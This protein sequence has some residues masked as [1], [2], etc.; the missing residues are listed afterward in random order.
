M[1]MRTAADETPTDDAD[2]Q[3]FRGARWKRRIFGAVALLLVGLLLFAWAQRNSIADRFVQNAFAARGVTA[4]YKIDTIGFRTQRIRDLVIG[5]PAQPD[6]TAKLLEIDVALNF[7]GANLRDVRADGV[8]L[9]GRYANGKISFGELDKFTD[10]KST[11][12]LELPDIALSLKNARA[13]IETP[14]GVFNAAANGSGLLRNRFTANLSVRSPGVTAA[15]CSAS[16]L[17]FD[18]KLMLEWRQPHLVGPITATAAKCADAGIAI[19]A[20]RLDADIKLSERFNRWEGTLGYATANLVIPQAQLKDVAGKLTI[21]GDLKRTNFA[22]LLDKAALRSAP[23]SVGRLQMDSKGYAGLANG[24]LALSVSGN[25]ALANGALDRGTVGDLRGLVAQTQATPVGPIVARMAPVLQ[26]A[27]DR[28]AARLDFESFQDFQGR[29]GGNISALSLTSASGVRLRQIGSFGVSGSPKGWQLNAPAQLTLSGT[30]LPDIR[31]SIAQAGQSW[32]GNLVIAPYSAG[33]AR[34]AVSNLAF[35]GNPGGAWRFQGQAKMSGPLPGGYVSGL[36]LPIAGRY[37]AGAVSL[38]DSC[39]NVRFDSLKMSSLALRGSAFWL[40]PDRGRSMFSIANGKAAFATNIAGFRAN[41]NLG[42]TPISGRSATVRFSLDEGFAARNVSIK[43][44]AEDAQSAFDVA[45]LSGRFGQDG[46]SG[47]L[48]GGAGEIG[49]VPLLMDNASG[50]WRYADDILTLNGRLGVTDAE[51]VDRFEPMIVPD[52][53]LTLENNVITAIGHLVEPTT[54]TRVAGVDIRH[55]L[56]SAT[57]RALLAVD[58]LRFT[59]RFQPDLLTS[60]VL[61]VAANVDGT[62]SGD[63]RIEWDAQG[64]RSTGK[65]ATRGM[66]LAAAFGPVEGLNTEIVFTDLLGLETGAAQ[67]AE[68]A[69]INPGVPA[70]G[71]KINYRLLPDR[72]V[73]IE[74][75]RWPFAGGELILEPTILDFEVES[76]R[77][78]TFRVIGVDAEKLLAGYDFQNLRVTGVFDGTLPMIFNQDGGRIVGGSLVSREGGG[79]VSYLGELTYK[80]MGVFANYAFSALRSIRYSTLTIG[81]GGDL[82]G[83]IVTDISFTGLQQGSLAKRNFITRQLARI[84]IKF[85]VSVTAEFMKLIGSIRGLYD[86]NYAADRDLQYLLEE[87]RA[88]TDAKVPASVQPTKETANE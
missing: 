36:N 84:P 44:G 26:R 67:V 68:I 27:G 48:S 86:A 35:N 15:D 74:S 63:G 17:K 5:N 75:G 59:E 83:E 49:N 43:L 29:L 37:N 16:A 54:G 81:V 20:P 64:V 18:G 28:F 62:V 13:R 9:R 14:W 31:L 52:L 7:S 12:P 50:E 8:M 23:L 21:D 42:R 60:L 33:N 10:P 73:A 6:L 38:Y 56:G 87:Q 82:D 57:G 19:A 77:R 11:D 22:L 46:I 40:C 88:P 76:E 72:R 45:A 24:R 1:V 47:A 58:E 34:L 30:N 78:L 69:S 80:D 66:N 79:E 85:N 55:A 4:T 61:G 32:S 41:G 70:L 39:Q 71:G 25:A 65:V 2:V 51:Q 53:L 3:P